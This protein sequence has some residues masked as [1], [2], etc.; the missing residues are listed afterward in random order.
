M[1][2]KSGRVKFGQNREGK[3]GVEG[4]VLV[5]V[6]GCEVF[7]LFCFR[8]SCILK[9]GWSGMEGKRGSKREE[10]GKQKEWGMFTLTCFC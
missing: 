7:T 5:K 6:K 9:V 2:N 8:Y 3:M 10:A 1:N 4:K